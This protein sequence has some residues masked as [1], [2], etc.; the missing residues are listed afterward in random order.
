MAYA[1]EFHHLS[2][3][4]VIY[5]GDPNYL[6]KMMV[7]GEFKPNN[8]LQKA[9]IMLKHATYLM[10]MASNDIVGGS[11][12]RKKAITLQK[13][14]KN[15]YYDLLHHKESIA[16]HRLLA[17]LLT[18]G[19]VRSM[20]T[21]YRKYPVIK[22][23]YKDRLRAMGF[24]SAGKMGSFVWPI[25]ILIILFLLLGLFI[26]FLPKRM[27]LMNM[28]STSTNVT[29]E[30]VNDITYIDHLPDIRFDGTVTVSSKSP[31][32][33]AK[34]I[35]HANMPIHTTYLIQGPSGPYGYA[36]NEGNG[37]FAIRILAGGPEPASTLSTMPAQTS[38]LPITP[39]QLNVAR[40]AYAYYLNTHNDIPPG[41]LTPIQ[42][43]IPDQVPLKR[44]HFYPS[45]SPAE[46]L[47]I[48]LQPVPFQSPNIEVN[49][50]EHTLM[51]IYNHQTLL[52]TKAGVG[53]AAQPTPTG[54]FTITD[55]ISNKSYSVY[56]DY[57]F[58]LN[59]SSLAIHGTNVSGRIG[60]NQ[61]LGCVEIPN[62]IDDQLFRMVPVGTPVVIRDKNNLGTQSPNVFR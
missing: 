39:Y 21:K 22:R 4:K 46:A 40:T 27:N 34:Q 11:S 6:Y 3:G 47:T 24:P 52:Q 17:P 50:S 45:T 32:D 29:R 26:L 15:I 55:R 20:M 51:L 36:V 53:S 25:L 13:E 48:P 38:N 41:S 18:I 33:I 58:P 23:I 2:T 37:H 62:H 8:P 14:A 43:M 10:L 60:A 28:V 7:S 61:S 31:S 57:I 9:D 12:L 5:E 16:V 54:T 49:L 42:S 44:I 59:H 19:E 1:D 35:D 30:Y 56:G